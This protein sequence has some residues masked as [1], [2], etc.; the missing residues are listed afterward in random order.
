MSQVVDAVGA[1]TGLIS[2][3]CQ[4]MV[5][6]SSKLPDNVDQLIEQCITKAKDKVIANGAS[7]GSLLVIEK[8]IDK[9]KGIYIKVVGDPIEDLKEDLME[10]VANIQT[11]DTVGDNKKIKLENNPFWPFENAHTAELDKK[12]G[13]PEPVI[14]TSINCKPVTRNFS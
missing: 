12:F 14:S 4:E 8:C 10:E 9:E 13:L 5:A 11:D 6:P 1:A 7:P 2:G 3:E